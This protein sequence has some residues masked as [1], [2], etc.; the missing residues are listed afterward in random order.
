MCSV[1]LIV[2]EIYFSVVSSLGYLNE[3][4]LKKK[5][6]KKINILNER[7]A[8]LFA[9]IERELIL[10]RMKETSKPMKQRYFY[11]KSSIYVRV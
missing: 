2:A 5:E 3:H 1:H 10:K 4:I 9:V 7:I 11:S 8:K 6:R